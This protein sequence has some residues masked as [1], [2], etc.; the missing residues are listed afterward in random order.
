M[1]NVIKSHTFTRHKTNSEI[2]LNMTHI[3]AFN[4]YFDDYIKN[5]ILQ[6]MAQFKIK[7]YIC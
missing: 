2:I 6:N 3:G 7:I 5:M 1:A 4:L